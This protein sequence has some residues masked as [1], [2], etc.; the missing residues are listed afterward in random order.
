MQ[1]ETISYRPT[2]MKLI[3][4]F[5]IILGA[6]SLLSGISEMTSSSWEEMQE[7]LKEISPDY[8]IQDVNGAAETEQN[9]PESTTDEQ[10]EKIE[11]PQTGVE[12][13]DK[14]IEQAINIPKWYIDLT[15]KIG[16][17]TALLALLYLAAG[18]LLLVQK[19]ARFRLL[20][21]ALVLAM[22]WNVALIGMASASGNW[23][24][25]MIIPSALGGLIIDA[26]F[27]IVCLVS[28]KKL[29][30]ELALARQSEAQVMTDPTN[31]HA[32]TA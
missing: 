10:S 28:G 19:Q 30:A 7:E 26:V 9:F 32:P 1:A 20:V 22:T 13:A 14:L 11:S 29:K 3:G 8:E 16:A 25:M 27:L 12:F 4:I 21:T 2:W 24:I 23:I 17:I 5:M 6:M 15:P 18:I 31:P